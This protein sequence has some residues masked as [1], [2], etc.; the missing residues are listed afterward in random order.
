MSCYWHSSSISGKIT[1]SLCPLLFRYHWNKC[2]GHEHCFPSAACSIHYLHY[3]P[4]PFE[5][6]HQKLSGGIN[7]HSNKHPSSLCVS[8]SLFKNLA[9]FV[10]ARVF[11]HLANTSSDLKS[12]E[13][14]WYFVFP[15]NNGFWVCA[16]KR[17]FIFL[18]SVRSKCWGRSYLP[19][20]GKSLLATYSYS[21]LS[22]TYQINNNFKYCL[23]LR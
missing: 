7:P 16:Y 9:C 19:W 21:I 5:I 15:P 8:Y 10:L 12:C 23:M 2:F 1:E 3:L 20:S 17:R 18:H 14:I 11:S 13:R 6:N 4:R 22:L